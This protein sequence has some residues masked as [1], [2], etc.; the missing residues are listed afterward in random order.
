MLLKGYQE[1][2][3]DRL[4]SRLLVAVIVTPELM[5]EVVAQAGPRFSALAASAAGARVRHLAAA[6]AFTDAALALLALELPQW[7]LRRL[8]YEDGEW[9]CT[10]GRHPALPHWLDETVEAHHAA[11]PLALLHALVRARAVSITT[12]QPMPRKVPPYRSSARLAPF[13]DDFR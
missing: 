9:L 12:A 2:S 13:C 1:S 10:L 8:L 3:L 5:S 6:G 4:E 11:L 7:T